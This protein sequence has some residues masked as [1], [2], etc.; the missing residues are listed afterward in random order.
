[1]DAGVHLCVPRWSLVDI[2][3]GY[4]TNCWI[5]KFCLARRWNVVW[6]SNSTLENLYYGRWWKCGN[7]MHKKTFL[8]D[9]LLKNRFQDMS[10]CTAEWK[11]VVK[12]SEHMRICSYR[13]SCHSSLR[14]RYTV[15][16]WY[17]RPFIPECKRQSK[18]D[19]YEF[20]ANWS[21]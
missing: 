15:Q 3:V 13:Y 7:T 1:M 20:E 21:T 5:C 12:V 10:T 4:S 9:P 18:V 19:L 11:H 14:M 16:V 8:S 6:S 17:C 2:D